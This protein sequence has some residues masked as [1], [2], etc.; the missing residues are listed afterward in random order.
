VA[1]AMST[2]TLFS[3]AT[4]VDTMWVYVQTDES[5]EGRLKEGDDATFTVDAYPNTVY[6]GTI[7]QQRK[8]ATT[9]Q[10]VVEY[11]T[12]L[13]FHNTDEKLFP[14]MTAYVNVP[15]A[16]ARNVLEVPNSALHFKPQMT[17]AQLRDTM[18]KYGMQDAVASV[19][20]GDTG[21]SAGG[22]GRG[23]RGG[24]RG[25]NAGGGGN[26][27][28]HGNGAET[29]ASGDANR[30]TNAVVWKLDNQQNLVP[31]QVRTGITDFTYTAINKVLKGSLQPGDTIVTGQLIVK[32]A[33]TGLPGTQ[34]NTRGR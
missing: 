8:F 33:T 24:G 31:V 3:E 4:D 20:G 28:A 12:I 17:P 26:A 21:S 10:N 7:L 1:S 25:A 30:P 9:V 29:A 19:G 5:D 2:P 27:A 13:Q 34:V 14:G 15:V 18:A 23:G 11:D 22:G 16:T 6:H 32:S